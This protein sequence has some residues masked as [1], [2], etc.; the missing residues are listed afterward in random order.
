MD[1]PDE[2]I[3]AGE[4]QT[5]ASISHP[6]PQSCQPNWHSVKTPPFHAVEN[7]LPQLLLPLAGQLLVIFARHHRFARPLFNI[8]AGSACHVAAFPCQDSQYCTGR[9]PARNKGI[10]RTF[11][12]ITQALNFPPCAEYTT[13]PGTNSDPPLSLPDHLL[14]LVSSPEKR[15]AYCRDQA[16]FHPPLSL[17]LKTHAQTKPLPPAGGTSRSGLEKELGTFPSFLI[18]SFILHTGCHASKSR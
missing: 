14:P 3:P 2:K 12:S 6:S 10:S 4:S 17:C 5:P 7:S 15:Y 18:I 16:F 9:I 13:P 11:L 1:I 8:P